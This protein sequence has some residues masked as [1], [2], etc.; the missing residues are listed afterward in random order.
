VANSWRSIGRIRRLLEPS[1]GAISLGVRPRHRELLR[2]TLV[3]LL[4]NPGCFVTDVARSLHGDDLGPTFGARYRRLLRFLASPLLCFSSLSL[5]Y[6]RSLRPE[7][8]PDGRIFLFAD[9]SDIAKPHARVME[10]LALVRDGSDP[11]HRIV[12]GYWLNQVYIEH[13]P[14]HLAPAV[15]ELY[16]LGRDRDLSQTHVLLRGIDEAFEVAGPRG[17]LVGDRGYDDGNIFGALLA[18]GRDFL[19]RIQAG[20]SARHLDLEGGPR[21]TAASIARHIRT[22]YLLYKYPEL[23]RPGWLG[24]ERVRLPDHPGRVLTV[25]VARMPRQ[26][27]P[28]VLLTSLP[29]GEE[30]AARRAV[31]AYLRRWG[32]AEDPVRYLKQTFD[33]E[34][35]LLAGFEAM[36]AWVFL[37]GVTMSLLTVLLRPRAGGERLARTVAWHGTEEPLFLY[38]RLARALSELLRRLTLPRLRSMLWARGP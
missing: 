27:E 22:P 23:R 21:A 7:P 17:V 31:A 9:I 19:I 11:G 3:G 32:G 35:Y 15:F 34:R 25:V 30:R 1:L 36:R 5:A 12:P 29:I 16:S 13:G 4:R 28:L 8:G 6:R 2:A 10:G 14:G 33:L 18:R 37:V 26:Q 38:Y 24:W 20:S